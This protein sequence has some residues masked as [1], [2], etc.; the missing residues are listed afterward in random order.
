MSIIPSL[1]DRELLNNIRSGV[2][3]NDAVR[4]LYREHFEQLSWYIFNN[5]GTSQDAEDIFQ[6]VMLD[7]IDAVQ[8]NKFRGESSI[9]TFLYSLNKFTW[10]NELKKRGRAMEREKKYGSLQPQEQVDVSGHIAGRESRAEVMAIVEQLGEACKKILVMFYYENL[11]MK[12]ILEKTDYDN[13]QVV[14]N[15]KYKCLKQLEQMLNAKPQLKES[16]KNAL[17]G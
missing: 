9:K 5:S 2:R 11:P 8:K 13:E 4:F 16:F 7:F 15:K 10:L 14:R 12:D 6:E 17:N 1:S 3:L